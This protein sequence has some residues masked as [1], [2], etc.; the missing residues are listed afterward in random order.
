MGYA[1]CIEAQFAMLYAY[2]AWRELLRAAPAL[3]N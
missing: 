1:G 2:R 3:R